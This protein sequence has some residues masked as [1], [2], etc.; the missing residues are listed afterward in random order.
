[1]MI[2]GYV[3][4]NPANNQTTV[5]APAAGNSVTPATVTPAPGTVAATPA[6]SPSASSVTPAPGTYIIGTYTNAP[7]LS[8]Y[9]DSVVVS[10]NVKE[11]EQILVTVTSPEKQ[12]KE[13]TFFGRKIYPICGIAKNKNVKV[14][15]A[16]YNQEKTVFE[17]LIFSKEFRGVEIKQAIAMWGFAFNLNLSRGENRFKIVAWDA[18]VEENKL[19]LGKSLQ[20]N[21]FTI[22]S[23]DEVI[24]TG[25]DSNSVDK[26]NDFLKSL[27]LK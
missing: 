17:E 8:T 19:D 20:V 16:V 24:I 14:T 7:K 11:T 25:R 9:L 26:L 3:S 13:Q 15:V 27:I 1:M 21:Y 18:D 6:A 2:S 5:T 22:N 4:A 10:G 12:L 23:L